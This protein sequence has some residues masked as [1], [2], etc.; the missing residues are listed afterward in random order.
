MKKTLVVSIVALLV[1]SIP[2]VSSA[3]DSRFYIGGGGAYNY[4]RFDESVVGPSLAETG[5]WITGLDL[6][7][8]NAF[9][10]SIGIGYLAS[11]NLA[12]GIDIGIISAFETTDT[13]EVGEY[14]GGPTVPITLDMELDLA[15]YMLVARWYWSAGGVRPFFSVGLGMLKAEATT[16]ATSMGVSFTE[17]YDDTD[18]CYQAGL[19]V[20]ISIN[21]R[22]SIEAAISSVTGYGDVENTDYFGI[23]VGIQY[24]F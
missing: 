14:I 22:T 4:E 16:T 3:E 17:T 9:G 24:R 1:V 20:D 18:M 10:L 7:F 6:D 13:V 15:T 12:L 5:L 23:Q 21:P 2:I 11:S 8:D 19:G